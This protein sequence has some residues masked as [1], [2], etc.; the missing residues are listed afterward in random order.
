MIDGKP[1]LF[2]AIEFDPDIATTDVLYDF[3]FPLMDLLAFGCDAVANRL[4][5]SY[6][7]VAWAEQS[8]C[9]LPAA[10]V[11]LCSRGNSRQRAR[12][13]NSGNIRERSNDRHDREKILRPRTA[14]DH[15]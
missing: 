3:A 1:V 14:A 4:F 12:S 15:P 8:A 9:A 5:N 13:L 11:S 6:I 10:A 2:D 7:Q